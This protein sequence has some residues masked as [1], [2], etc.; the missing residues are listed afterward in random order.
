MASKNSIKPDVKDGY[1]HIYNRGVEKRDIF[2]DEQDYK[3]FLG[4]LKEFF[5]RMG[6]QDVKFFPSYFPYTEPSV[7]V[8]VWH[9]ERKEWIELGGA[10]VFR[11]ELTVPLLGE[12][13]PVLAW[14]QGFDR[15]IMDY[16][17]IKDL[18]EMYANDL[19]ILREKS[20]W[21]K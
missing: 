15:I 2:L 17:K 16:Y 9:S 8:Q 1:Y 18:R 7:E 19:K 21:I 6:F 12:A 5:T 14:G 11:P 3:V 4:Y 20:S 13:I 10:G